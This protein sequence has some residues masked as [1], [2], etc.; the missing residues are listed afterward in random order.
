MLYRF[1]IT[2]FLCIIGLVILVYSDAKDDDQQNTDGGSNIN[3]NLRNV[4]GDVMVL[5]AS[6]CYSISNVGGE[7]MVKTGDWR[8]YLGQLV[9]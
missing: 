6:V 4:V 9:R 2:A 5:G 8:L 3:G 1:I 7:A